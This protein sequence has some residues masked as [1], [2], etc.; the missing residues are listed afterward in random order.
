M[1][2]KYV[3]KRKELFNEIYPKCKEES[4]T[5]SGSFSERLVS[6]PTKQGNKLSF[7]TQISGRYV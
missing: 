3:K 2:R 4:L 5:Y 6:I 1:D 7:S